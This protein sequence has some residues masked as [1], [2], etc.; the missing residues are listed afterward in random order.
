MDQPNLRSLYDLIE[1][2]YEKYHYDLPYKSVKDFL[3]NDK[4]SAAFIRAVLQDKEFHLPDENSS[5]YSFAQRRAPH[6]VITYF[7][8]L[9]LANYLNL[10]EVISTTFP[11]HGKNEFSFNH[12][13]ML[14]A[15]YHDWG[16]FSERVKNADINFREEVKYYLL[17]DI[18]S[19][20]KLTP[21]K[22]F[23]HQH[24]AALAYDYS[25]IEEYDSYARQYHAAREKEERK[26]R[27]ERVDHGILGGIFKFDDLVKK[28]SYLSRNHVNNELLLAK[29][30]CIT[31]AQ[32]NI[33]KSND[34]SE[35]TKY[36][37]KPKKLYYDS[38]F[39]IDKTTPLLLLLSLV[40]TFE[41]VKRLGKGEN[42]KNSLQI[43]TVLRSIMLKVTEETISVDYSELQKRVKDKK[44]VELEKKYDRY[45]NGLRSL[46]KW[47]CLSYI[48]SENLSSIGVN[49][50]LLVTI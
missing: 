8:G 44:N 47:T 49:P 4:E 12:L 14:T 6:S 5:Q 45:I 20:K 34:P 13:W 21:L 40:D 11:F 10:S 30:A 3:H 1:D 29:T 50:E 16:Y 19:E 17:T 43:E 9:A 2:E 38:P 15:L 27:I 41:C 7:I 23:S 37:P 26:K 36:G 25:E 28:A 46:N 33:F 42:E 18:Y 31:I 22:E 48:E 35:D 24:S 39:V 32:H